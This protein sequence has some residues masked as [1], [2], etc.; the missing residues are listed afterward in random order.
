MAG[1]VGSRVVRT[2]EKEVLKYPAG[3]DAIESVVLRAEDAEE[4]ASA[5]GGVEGRLAILAGTIL[6]RVD[7]DR[8]YYKP[9]DGTGD[10]AGVLGDNI[11]FHSAADERHAADMLFHACVFN[12]N[13]IR[14]FDDYE[15]E[16]RE[17]LNTCRFEDHYDSNG[18]LID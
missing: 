9:F 17:A 2:V 16:L 12:K 10:P 14:E 4:V 6:E 1:P 3:L 7:A 5:V 11:Y 8:D 15:T 18:E 13:K